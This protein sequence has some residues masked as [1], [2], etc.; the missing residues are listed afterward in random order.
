MYHHETPGLPMQGCALSPY[1]YQFRV[2]RSRSQCFDYWEWFLTHYLPFTPKVM[3]LH[4]Q[5]TQESRLWEHYW[6]YGMKA[7]A[8]VH[9]LLEIIKNHW[10]IAAFPVQCTS[11]STWNFKHWKCFPVHSCFLIVSIIMILYTPTPIE[12]RMCPIDFGV[13]F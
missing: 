9:W 5:T 2:Q 3:K 11:S 1:H 6:L 10:W 7:K 12:A 13:K 4:T 8:T